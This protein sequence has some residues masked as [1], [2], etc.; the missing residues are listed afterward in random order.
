MA[1]ITNF[2]IL[3]DVGSFP[4]PSY[5]SNQRFDKYYWDAFKAILKNYDIHKNQGLYTNVVHPIEHTFQLKVQTGM[6]VINYPQIVDM[7]SQF[8]TPMKEYEVKNE[9]HLIE[10]KFARLLEVDILQQWAKRNYE[11]SGEQIRLKVCVTGPLELYFKE[12]GFSVYTDM[13]MNFSKSVNRFLK[14]SIVDSKYMKTEI[15][16]IDEP[17]LGYVS[18]S[19]A[20]HDD[21]VKIYDKSVEGLNCDV[22]IHLHSLNSFKIPLE[23][24][25]IN[26][27]TCEFASNNQNVIDR[28]Y[29]E[30]FDKFIRVGVC[31]TN[32]NAIMADAL[33][34]GMEYQEFNSLEGLRKL[35]DSPERIEKNLRIAHKQYG[36]RLKY[37]GPDCGLNAWAP[38][39]L[40]TE[41]LSRTS[42]V[43]KKFRKEQ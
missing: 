24:K 43:V 13:A 2:P 27:M 26:I 39:E 20:E 19:G 7:Y 18:I 23:T 38:V 16:A 11:E 41:L 4:L 1:S 25:H 15:V 10:P 17:S 33:D 40:A 3:D 9:P 8:L 37:V 32:F 28:K 22:Q 6:E 35:I 31:R 34:A 12:I 21:L 42:Q 14:N 36:D 5:T 29:L 30:D